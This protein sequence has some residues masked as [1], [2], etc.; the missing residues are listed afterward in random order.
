MGRV[1]S[2]KPALTLPV[3]CLYRTTARLISAADKHLVK[4]ELMGLWSMI[5]RGA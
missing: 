3:C 4:T 2:S 1:S 5:R